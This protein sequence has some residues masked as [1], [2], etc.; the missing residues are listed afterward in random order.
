MGQLDTVSDKGDRAGGCRGCP[1][2][3][4]CSNTTVLNRGHH[5]EAPTTRCHQGRCRTAVVSLNPYLYFVRQ[6]VLRAREGDQVSILLVR[7]QSFGLSVEK[8]ALG[9]HLA[10]W[11]P[12]CPQPLCPP[13]TVHREGGASRDMLS[14]SPTLTTCMCSPA[15][16]LRTWAIST[17]SPPPP[18]ILGH[19]ASSSSL[20]SDPASNSSSRPNCRPCREAR[21][22][23]EPSVRPREQ[24]SSRLHAASLWVTPLGRRKPADRVPAR[25]L[26]GYRC[27]DK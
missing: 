21:C 7:D 2:H 3:C 14:T 5:S 6:D 27:L 10:F 23:P 13:G 15:T 25:Q 22:V 20:G 16:L 19:V 26:W 4:V 1:T 9:S 8:Q 18:P 24:P 17:L 11:D 12:F